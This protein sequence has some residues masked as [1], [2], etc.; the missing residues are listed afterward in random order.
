MGGGWGGRK[1]ESGQRQRRGRREVEEDVV[2]EVVDT[3][4]VDEGERF[5]G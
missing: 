1:R 5:G 4:L 2:D 3:Q